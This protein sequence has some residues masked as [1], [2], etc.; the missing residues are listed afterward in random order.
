MELV[1]G[2]A[3]ALIVWGCEVVESD[4][5]VVRVTEEHAYVR[6]RDGGREV[7][8]DLTP[9]RMYAYEWESSRVTVIRQGEWEDEG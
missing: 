2:Q 8:Y 4:C 1:A 7:R 3:I 9:C 6:P 5:E